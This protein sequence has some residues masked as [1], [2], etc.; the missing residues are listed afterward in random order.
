MTLKV[1]AQIRTVTL[2]VYAQDQ[3]SDKVYGRFRR[4]TLMV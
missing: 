2:K 1:Y 3:T 4:V